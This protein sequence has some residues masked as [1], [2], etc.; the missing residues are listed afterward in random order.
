MDRTM[1]GGGEEVDVKPSMD[2][3]AATEAWVGEDR[4]SGECRSSKRTS[5]RIKNFILDTL[6]PFFNVSGFLGLAIFAGGMWKVFAKLTKHF[7][8]TFHEVHNGLSD[9]SVGS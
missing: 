9:C 2:P 1:G 6:V 8:K 4:H 3:S 7:E 5:A